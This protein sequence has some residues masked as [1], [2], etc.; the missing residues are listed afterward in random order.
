MTPLISLS[1]MEKDIRATHGVADAEAL[2]S[3]ALVRFR[4]A[5]RSLKQQTF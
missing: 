3:N 4:S 5:V 2:F 1:C